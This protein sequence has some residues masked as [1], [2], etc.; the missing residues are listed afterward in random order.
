MIGSLA[1]WAAAIGTTFAACV[2][3]WLA[4]RDR[5][6]RERDRKQS[7][8][9]IAQLLVYKITHVRS[10]FSQLAAYDPATAPN[11]EGTSR[12]LIALILDID[13][14]RFE[15]AHANIAVFDR[16]GPFLIAHFTTVAVEARDLLARHEIESQGNFD[17]E[18]AEA[19]LT[20][21][22]ELAGTLEEAG[23]DLEAYLLAAIDRWKAIA[24]KV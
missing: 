22:K 24:P 20:L 9:A 14:S 5:R 13:P 19:T 8:A 16:P 11:R 6:S 7:A 21:A 12:F 17:L 10:R 18:R 3:L 1:D 15:I 2:A 23:A 4:S